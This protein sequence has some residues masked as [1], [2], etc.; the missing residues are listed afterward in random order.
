M[1]GIV[2]AIDLTGRRAF[3]QDAL[4]AMTR[5]LAHRGPDDEQAHF[6]D[7]VAL[8]ARRLAFIDVAG[9][10]QPISNE[11]G[12]VWV[13]QEGELYEYPE[14]R[15]DLLARG[16]VL[17]TRC[18]TEAWVHLYED[19]GEAV[20]QHTRGQYSASLWDRNTRTLLLGRDR[21][22]IAPLFY[23]EAD[24]WLLWASEVKALFASR[25]VEAR[26]DR[27]GLDFFFNFFA[28]SGPRTC[29]EG[30]N[31]L[32]PG[33][34]L[35]VRDGQVSVRRYAD[36]DYP[37][38][39]SERHDLSASAAADELEALLRDAIRRRLVGEA[40]VC[41]YISGGLDSTTILSLGSEENGAPLQS[42]TISLDRSGPADEGP[43]ARQAADLIGSRLTT[44][45]MTAADICDAFPELI[46][47]AESPVLDTSAAC[48]IRLAQAVRPAGCK[49]TLTGEGADEALA[50]YVWFKLDAIGIHPNRPVYRGL[51]RLF[52]GPIVGG[53]TS[54]LPP[55][56]AIDGMRTAQQLTYEMM[57][58]SRD[59]LYS[60]DM[61]RAIDGYRPYDELGL[62]TAR[63]RRWHPLNRS[64]YVANKVM[65]AGMLLAAKGDRPIRSA[66]IE[67][68]FPFLDERV[69]DFC[70]QLPPKFKLNGRTDKWLLR[71]VARRALPTPI[72]NRRKTMFR[73]NLSSLFLT[74]DR[75]PWVD[76]LLSADSLA[77]SGYF[78]HAAVQQVRDRLER[79]KRNRFLNTI[80]EMGL[81]G[82]ITTQ[83]WHHTFL[84]GGLADL[85]EWQPPA[86][87][88][89][90]GKARRYKT[91]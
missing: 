73:A 28:I 61:W 6:E 37:D 83:L 23:A 56:A 84:G 21:A 45:R 67:G 3:P 30:V 14:I 76:Q 66:S 8:G 26:A 48:M 87:A 62:D 2:G 49:T 52:F 31:Q 33:H 5:S 68:R 15:R 42:F 35:K 79:V 90:G 51:R 19:F 63:M 75:P 38:R 58:S 46:T 89:D 9:G 77:A 10:R 71:E 88:D 12:T 25:F 86:I 78:D 54:R 65:L 29:F 74:A 72:A 81:T 85:P 40:E 55:F 20:F 53:N 16:H 80:L 24:G 7:G 43:K 60:H 82:V 64:L 69:V 17:K 36:I 41:S 18:D 11:N 50:G 57:A 91:A 32:L 1:C 70:A 4:W 44:V 47:A 13:A 39:G 22:G 27:R 59:R 34:Y